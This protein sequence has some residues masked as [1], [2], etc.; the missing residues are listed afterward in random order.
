MGRLRLASR[1]GALAVLVALAAPVTALAQGRAGAQGPVTDP[2]IHD[3]TMIQADGTYY[4][5]GT[6]R[7]IQV[8]SSPDMKTWTHLAPVFATPPA[9]AAKVAPGFQGDFWAPDISF[10]DGTYYLYY[11]VSAFGRNASAVGLATNRT[12]DPKDPEFRWVDHGVVVRSVPGRDM[13]NAIDPQLFVDTDGT[14][15]LDFG[16]FWDGIKL[17]KLSPDFT[18]PADPP[19]WRTIAARNRYWKLDER[20]AGDAANPTIGVDTLY[21]PRILQM[22]QDMQSGSLE[23]PF[24]FHA[25]GWYYLFVSWNRCCRGVNSTYEVVVGRS[26]DVR[27]PYLDRQG[28]K[29]IDGGGS[30]VVYGFG[31]GRRWAAGGHEAAYTFGGTD[32]LILH[33]YDATDQG[34]SKLIA[35]PIEWS[36]DG[37]PTVSLGR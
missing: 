7:G 9:W 10:H 26:H 27:G 22:E 29:M 31:D 23:A 1:H 6:G 30:M 17:V 5:F 12:L 32:Y 18:K 14:P 19:D 4:L 28:Q 11:A 37:W 24:I 34:R 21:P 36:E 33:G 8:W 13:W 25:H 2:P 15:W 35:K 16:S 20:D 3:P